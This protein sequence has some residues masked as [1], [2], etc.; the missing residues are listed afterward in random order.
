MRYRL[1]GIIVLENG[2]GSTDWENAPVN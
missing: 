1:L 2:S